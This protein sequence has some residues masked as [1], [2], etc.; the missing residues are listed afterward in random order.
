MDVK[1]ET[2]KKEMR[3]ASLEKERRLY[4]WLIISAGLLLVALVIMLLL[5]IKNARK[6]RRIIAAEALQEG[7]ISE[8]DRIAQDLHDRLGGSLT[9]VK[10]GLKNAESIQNFDGKID[11][12]MKELRDITNNIMPRSLKKF[13]M[14][15]AL[16]DFSAKLP[17]LHFH[18]FG[19][20]KRI[21]LNQEYVVYCCAR[22]LVNNALKHSGATSINLQLIQRRRHV[23]LTVQDNGCGFE[24]KTVMKGDGLQNIRNRIGTCK[25]K[26]DIYSTPGKGT[27]A[28]IELKI[29]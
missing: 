18:F 20:E 25:G 27:E 7:E 28:V 13:G 22:E 8:R 24:E 15:G 10:I 6:Q 3:I 14:K 17:N 19:E 5:T 23:S 16:E 26:I 12:C 9:A 21:S 4:L 1:Y 2:E 11:T 29:L